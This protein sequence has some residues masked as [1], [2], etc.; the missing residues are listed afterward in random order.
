LCVIAMV[1]CSSI[2]VMA[3]PNSTTP[4]V[5]DP[6]PSKL[7][8]TYI[9]GIITSLRLENHGAL[10]SFR[11]VVVHYYKR[12]IGVRE[13]GTLSFFQRLIVPNNFQGI[14]GVHLIMARFPEY[15]QF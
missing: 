14:L 12:G 10:F 9:Q 7:G 13:S 4:I 15:I 1:Y 5:Q 8:V 3:Q 6:Q 2:P 11:C